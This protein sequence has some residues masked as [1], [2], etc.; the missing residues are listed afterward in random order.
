MNN[1]TTINLLTGLDGGGDDVSFILGSGATIAGYMN[2]VKKS[3]A[4]GAFITFTTTYV[5]TVLYLNS[6]IS[7]NILTNYN[8]IVDKEGNQLPREGVIVNV[9]PSWDSFS[10]WGK[11]AEFYDKNTGIRL[12]FLP[13]Y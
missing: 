1:Q 9:Y 2:F 10:G 4:V 12:G 7:G 11:S 6:K 8:N 3:P 13:F 5:S